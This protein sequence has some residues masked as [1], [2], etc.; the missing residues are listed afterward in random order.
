MNGSSFPCTAVLSLTKMFLHLQSR[1]W[2][3][4]Q[5]PGSLENTGFSTFPWMGLAGWAGNR[6]AWPLTWT[7]FLLLF[8]SLFPLDAVHTFKSALTFDLFSAPFQTHL[9]SVIPWCWLASSLCLPH[10]LQTFPSIPCFKWIW[11]L[12]PNSWY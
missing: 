11:L 12:P 2:L 9:F 7:V 6:I 3:C 4:H 10:F 8:S 5:C 1:Q